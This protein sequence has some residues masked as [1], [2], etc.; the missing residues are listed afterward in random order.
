MVFHK[1]QK[2]IAVSVIAS[3]IATSA[4][5]TNYI[6][7]LEANAKT[8]DNTQVVLAENTNISENDEGVFKVTMD[9]TGYITADASKYDPDG[10]FKGD[11]ST[12]FSWDNVNI[13]FVI[14]D[15]FNNGDKSNDH[16]YGRSGTSSTV[17]ASYKSTFEEVAGSY[18]SSGEQGASSYETRV[19]T[20]HGGDLKGLTEYIENGYFDALGTNAFWITAPYEQVH[21]AVFG[22]GYKH[23]SY[24]GYY[25]L[26]Y[27]EVDANMGTE[28]ELHKFIDTAHEHGIRVVF[29]VV[30]NHSGYPDAYTIAEFYGANSSLLTSKWQQ[31]YFGESESSYT[32]EWDYSTVSSE[33]GALNFTSDWNDSWF[34][35]SWQRM[36]AGRYSDA[37]N[38]TEDNPELTGCS[39]GLPDFK[40]EDTSGKGLPDILSKKW[41]KEGQLS[42][43]TA[44]TNQMLSACGYGNIGSASVKQYLVAWLANWVREYGVDGYRCDTAKHVNFDCWKDLNTECNKALKEWRSNNPDKACSKWTDDFWMTGEVYDQGLS[45]NY[46]GTDYSQAFD[47]LI[48]FSF[49]GKAGQKG[50]ALESTYSEYAAYCNNGSKQNALS[51]VSSHDKGIGA[52]GASV[53]TALLLCPGGVQTYYGDETSR[54]PGGGTGDQ[55]SRS[56][57][58]WNDAAC[59]SNWQKVGR[60]RKNHIAVGA[61]KHA[62]I[63]DSPYT[64]SRTYTGTA[65]V[66][67][68][69]KTDYEDKVVV[70]LPGSAGTY[71]VSVGT[72]FADGT[73]VVDEYSGEEYTVSGG[74]VAGVSCDS[75]GVILIAEP[76][77]STPKA[78]IMSSVLRGTESGGVYNSD[79]LTLTL[80]TQNVKD[81]SYQINNCEP[82]AFNET[83]EVTIGEDTAYEEE[84]VLI[85]KGTSEID[86]EAVSKEFTYSR[87]KEPV[88]GA[89]SEGFSLRVKKSDFSEA[90]NIWIWSGQ[91][92]YCTNVWPGDTLTDDGDYYVYNNPEITGSA[93]FIISQGT[94][95]NTQ[96]GET[97]LSANG[98]VL[99]DKSSNSVDEYVVA[100]GESCKVTVEYLNGSREV[101]KTI[102]RVGAEGDTYTIYAPRTLST[103]P[104]STLADGEESSVSGTF[105]TE[106]KTIQFTYSVNGEIIQTQAPETQVPETP[107]PETQV[108]E[109]PAP[110]T[111]VP[112]TPAPE[113]PAPNTQAPNTQA[114]NTQAPN[115]QAPNTQAPSTPTLIPVTPEPEE[116]S[117]SLSANKKSVVAGK[118]VKFTA[119][120][121]GGN[122][123]YTYRFDAEKG[124]SS[125]IIRAFAKT[126]TFSWK[127]TKVG[128]YTIVVYAKD[129]ETGIMDTAEVT[130]KVTAAPL[131]ITLFK[132]LNL[133]KLKV[134]LKANATG[135]TGTLQYRYTYTYKGKTKIIKKYSGTKS[136]KKVMKKA[137]TYT[138]KVYVRDS[139]NK[140][141]IKTKTFKLKV[142]KKK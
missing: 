8:T 130:V 2:T 127:P 116:F 36:V 83:T 4:P 112:E 100:T 114:P 123:S 88:I 26:D 72:V 95:R 71:D 59:L 102:T 133:G 14:T 109:T 87:G 94:Y 138:F 126:P 79:S 117:V 104:G 131:T 103:V 33:H 60:F 41:A 121:T 63:A 119:G 118:A 11:E 39:S 84:T 80:S 89:A 73:T 70:C 93:S 108:P 99:F 37:Y 137:G 15:R 51:Y 38:N 53:G 18:A 106:G 136:L 128:T 69:K 92:N 43:K 96:E 65:T 6:S 113:T 85:I 115:T 29:D 34:T 120:V 107:A 98:S 75:N 101:I 111:Q 86:G 35:T 110:G 139:K 44:E 16:S 54:Q 77:V 47:S 17:P 7:I 56:Q 5:S 52:R 12:P 13:Y 141:T 46:G 57:M 32:W 81:A 132:V 74:K 20:F 90:P 48:N 21:G 61:G 142:K 3:L 58:T 91:T 25:T 50:S 40:T 62:K 49:Q 9:D 23:Y 19:G 78:K 66:G 140:K 105:T 1:I 30:M 134:Q 135:G 55:P 28:E 97:E 31:S 42:E 122:G 82:I 22:G 27:T 67:D 10:E 45:M 125:S 124:A 24:H 64:F 129:M 68:E 76:T